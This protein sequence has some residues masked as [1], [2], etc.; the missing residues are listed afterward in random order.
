MNAWLLACVL[1]LVV[2]ILVGLW[3]VAVGPRQADRM[4]AAQLM[5]T[6]GVAIL[7]LLGQVSGNRALQ[8]VA[9]VLALVSMVASVAFVRQRGLSGSRGEGRRG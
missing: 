3:R 1:V 5:G 2:T 4:L 8:D 9:L 7:L 6:T